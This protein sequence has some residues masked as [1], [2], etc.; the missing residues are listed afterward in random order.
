MHAKAIFVRLP[1]ITVLICVCLVFFA[2]PRLAS[3]KMDVRESMVK[4]Y[5]VQD[6]PDYDNPW[7]MCGPEAS[8]G[9]GCVI[10][11]NRILTNAHVVSDQTFIQVRLH[12]KSKKHPA[13]MLAVSHEADLA[14]LTVENQTFFHGIKPLLFGKLPEVQQ[15]VVVYG[16]PRGGDT[17]STTKGVISRIEHQRYS[18]STL[19]L[20]A[21]QLDAAVNPGNSGGPVMVGDRIV[22]VVMQSLRNSEN[23]GYMVPIP[24]VRHFLE[25][26]DDGRYDGFPVIGICCQPMENSA[27]KKMHGLSEKQSGA[28]V[29][30]VLPGTPAQ[31]KI[32]PGDV[33]LSLDGCNVADDRTVE[34]RHG[35]RTSMNYCIQRHQVGEEMSLRILREGK[36]QTIRITLDQAWGHHKL[37][38]MLRHDV[39]PTYYIYGGLVFCPLTMNYLLTWGNKPNKDSPPN[40]IYFLINDEPTVKGEEVV[41]I[42]KVLPSE[43]NNGYKALINERITEVNGKKIENLRALICIVENNDRDRFVVFENKRGCKIV[44]DRKMVE[45]EQDK[46]LQTYRVPSDRSDD[47]R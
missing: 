43:V 30:S 21:A 37:V 1:K 44:L 46:I 2:F 36:E 32:F 47:L 23:I 3:A 12:G 20:L 14:L 22:G 4:I 19:R 40:L 34:F 45:K 6:Q 28:L 35:E 38:P 17:L 42:V 5:T 33:I 8:S 18:Q 31:G 25:D 24:V 9:S 11:G 16:F 27:I 10:K 26:V 13:R 29:I 15:D 39:L 41:I 7:N